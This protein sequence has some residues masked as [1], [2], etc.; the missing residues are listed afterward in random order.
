MDGG[1]VWI[2]ADDGWVTRILFNLSRPL[3]IHMKSYWL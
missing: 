3:D 2:Q 1:L